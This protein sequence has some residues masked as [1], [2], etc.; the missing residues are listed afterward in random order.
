MAVDFAWGLYTIYQ[1]GPAVKVSVDGRRETMYRQDVYL[2]N[3]QFQFGEGDWDAL[4]R[5]HDTELAL[6]R[7]GFPASNLMR[8]KPGWRLVYADPTAELYA[9]DGVARLG[10]LGITRPPRLPHDGRGRFFP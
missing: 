3:L 9:R 2:E 10:A 4:L 1:L 5:N 6:V 7:T 8:L